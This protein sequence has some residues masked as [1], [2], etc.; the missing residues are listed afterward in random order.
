MAKSKCKHRAL[1]VSS[2]AKTTSASFSSLRKEKAAGSRP[3]GQ[4]SKPV[5]TGIF[6]N[7]QLWG[8]WVPKSEARTRFPK[9]VLVHPGNLVFLLGTEH[10]VV[11]PVK[12]SEP[13]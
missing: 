13:S 1:D 5:T 4:I 9:Q 7:K 12:I 6:K 8:S 10:F 2:S 11:R 3:L